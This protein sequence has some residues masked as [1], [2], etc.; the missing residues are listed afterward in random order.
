MAIFKVV[1]T[2]QPVFPMIDKKTEI[3]EPYLNL[4]RYF[5]NR[6]LFWTNGIKSLS[7]C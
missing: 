6:Q 7:Y 2:K 1:T 5:K 3:A 4:F